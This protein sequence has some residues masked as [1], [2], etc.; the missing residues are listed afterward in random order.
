MTGRANVK[1]FLSGGFYLV[2]DGIE[3]HSDSKICKRLH[4][5]GSRILG[6]MEKTGTM[7]YLPKEINGVLFDSNSSLRDCL[8]C[9]GPPIRTQEDLTKNFQ[10]IQQPLRVR[11]HS[12]YEIVLDENH[13]FLSLHMYF[14][15]IS[16]TP[17][18][19]DQV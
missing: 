5:S 7:I 15:D 8:P 16:F 17:L 2:P 6:N 13:C 19:L 4:E 12:S 14:H 11:T 3:I 9:L 1:T 10:L 18:S